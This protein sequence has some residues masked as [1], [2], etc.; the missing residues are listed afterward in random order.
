MP[1]SSSPHQPQPR[2][3]RSAS[4]SSPDPRLQAQE[5]TSP[6][7]NQGFSLVSGDDDHVQAASHALDAAADRRRAPREA[8]RRSAK[9][10]DAQGLRYWAA[11]TVDVSASGLL[12]EVKGSGPRPGSRIR[13]AVAW[14][15]QGFL[16][17]ADLIEARV[18]RGLPTA[19]GGCL[20]AVELKAAEAIRRAA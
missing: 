13:V 19:D 5:A 2:S 9:L 17:S 20:V 18:V 4:A 1:K 14:G 7:Q 11:Q 8:I 12:L 16:R 6:S 10:S 3:S 15:G